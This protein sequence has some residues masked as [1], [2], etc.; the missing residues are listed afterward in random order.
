MVVRKM[1]EINFVGNIFGGTGYASHS[2]SLVNALY[3]ENPDIKLETP[4][5]NGWELMVN[6]AEKNMILNEWYNDG[7]TVCINT[8]PSWPAEMTR[9][10]K[11]FFGFCVWEGDRVPRSWSRH[12]IKGLIDGILVPSSHVEEA[13]I[14]TC[15]EAY[16]DKP[17]GLMMQKY[18][19]IHIIP[20]G[21]D[22]NLFSPV[23]VEAPDTTTVFVANKGWS[24]G[25]KDRGGVQYLLRAF[26]EEFGKEE[27]VLLKL[28]INPSYCPPGWNLDEE[29]KKLNLPEDRPPMLISTDLVDYKDLPRFYEGDVFVSPSM[30]EG[31]NLPCLEAMSAGLPVI[32]TG[33]GGQIDFVNEDNGWLLPYELT[34][35]TWEIA[36]EGVKWAMPNHEALKKTLRYVFEH[37]EEVAE[38]GILAREKALEYTWRAS[39]GKLL[40]VIQ[41][42]LKKESKE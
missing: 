16:I 42:Y 33:F 39:A 36:Y 32:T 21:V 22:T 20:H 6:D 10:C 30:A 29:L 7:V 38:K 14:R 23:E 27:P 2:R 31:F 28:K 19:P 8:P 24:K 35:V 13:I 12:L 9:P 1:V 40:S 15:Q 41:N 37:P 4:L 34:E 3:E 11:A 5:P 17:S 26:A 18:A 25:A